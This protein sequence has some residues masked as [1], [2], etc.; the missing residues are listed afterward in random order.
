MNDV[1]EDVYTNG[2]IIGAGHNK[3][4]INRRAAS[5]P[6]AIC[7][8]D[9]STNQNYRN[10]IQIV[11]IYFQCTSATEDTQGNGICLNRPVGMK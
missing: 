6:T 4:H 11:V 8:D 5:Q 2:R 1:N 3:N 10:R 7:D 9:L